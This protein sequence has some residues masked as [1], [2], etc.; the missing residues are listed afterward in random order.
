MVAGRTIALCFICR[1]VVANQTLTMDPTWESAAEGSKPLRIP[2]CS[3]CV[4][5]GDL[6]KAMDLVI[7]KV[8][9]I[10]EAVAWVHRPPD[11]GAAAQGS[12]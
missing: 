7:A 2:F 12:L 4:P 8:D 3:E 10:S 5:D 6:D 9:K 11:V 1:R